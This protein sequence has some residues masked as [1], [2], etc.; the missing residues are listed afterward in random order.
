MPIS[1]R[2]LALC[3]DGLSRHDEQAPMNGGGRHQLHNRDNNDDDDDD[4]NNNDDDC[5]VDARGRTLVTPTT[6][7]AAAAGGGGAGGR[8]GRPLP[9][10]H[11]AE[12]EALDRTAASQQHNAMLRP[13]F[14][15]LD[16]RGKV[17]AEYIW[18][19]GSG[20]DIRS[21]VR[22]LDRRPTSAEDVP[23]WHVDGSCS[24]QAT[25]NNFQVLLKPHGLFPDPFRQG[26]HVLVL[27]GT[28]L[29]VQEPDTPV[30][31]HITNNRV[32]CE[33]VMCS[34]AES[35]PMFSVEQEYTIINPATSWLVS[36]SVG[37]VPMEGRP[38]YCGAG[39][40]V[41]AGREIYEAHMRACLY[42]G[43]KIAGASATSTPGQW[44]FRLG[45]CI[46]VALADELW[47]SRYI[48]LR[49]A[50][51]FQL[52]VSFEPEPI[53]GNLRTLSCHVEFS[54]QETRTPGTGLQEIETQVE[55]LRASHVKHVIAYGRG[56]LQRMAARPGDFLRQRSQEFSC[57]FGNKLSSIMIP[58]TV[59]INRGGHY[60]DQRPASNM[61]PY[62]VTALIVSSALG[63][64]LPLPTAFQVRA[65]GQGEGGG[66]GGGRDGAD[67][68]C[69]ALEEGNPE[70]AHIN[71]WEESFIN[72][73]VMHESMIPETPPLQRFL[74]S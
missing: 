19:G 65:E 55:R 60:V 3:L 63:I 61:D 66:P 54:T 69:D 52:Q 58:H 26:D 50:E 62:L 57:G 14:G 21:L 48:L 4:D 36:C 32:P 42:T 34:A 2:N 22:V 39:G 53:P 25:A 9:L 37:T 64:P 18:L 47:I 41:V 49:V 73:L 24:G 44:S 13:Q 30:Q 16:T 17:L 7:A 43:L 46:G 29:I 8:H 27:C 33:E 74:G 40:G 6:A 45:P 70:G 5:G 35:E 68:D 56:Y 10:A 59:R 71:A 28:Y 67:L 72:E 1:L 31:P 11:T 23:T 51:S 20:T 15:T 38:S 12:P